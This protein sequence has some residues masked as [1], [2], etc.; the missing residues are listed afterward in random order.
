MQLQRYAKLAGLWAVFGVVLAACGP[1]ATPPVELV[2]THDVQELLA[3]DPDV[4][5]LPF[6]DNPDPTQCG[7][8]IRWGKEEPAWLHGQYQGELVQPTVQLYDS[9]LRRTIVGAAPCGTNVR[10][11]LYQQNPVLDFYLVETIELDTSQ[12]GWVPGPFLEFEPPG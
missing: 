5:D 8:P 7:I 6:P 11:K 1:A 2:V 3:R 10:I 9:H 12:E 4:P